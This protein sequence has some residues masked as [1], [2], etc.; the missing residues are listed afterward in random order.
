MGANASKNIPGSGSPGTDQ[1]E[2]PSSRAGTITADHIELRFSYDSM[3][4]ARV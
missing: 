1:G 2:Q 3:I 4:A